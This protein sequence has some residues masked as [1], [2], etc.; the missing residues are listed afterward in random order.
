MA[1]S[2]QTLPFINQMLQPASGAAAGQGIADF[3]GG[4][5]GA[6]EARSRIDAADPD[7][8][9]HKFQNFVKAFNRTPGVIAE[10]ATPFGGSKGRLLA[11]EA[12]GLER[13]NSLNDQLDK[14]VKDPAGLAKEVGDLPIDQIPD[15]LT[16][17]AGLLANP[18]G[19][20][21]WQG[22]AEGYKQ[23]KLGQI[24]AGRIKYLSQLA[25][26]NIDLDVTTPEGLEEARRRNLE[27]PEQIGGAPLS[28][29]TPD[30][31]TGLLRPGY[32]ARDEALEELRR[33]Q[34]ERAT[35]QAEGRITTGTTPQIVKLHQEMQ[36]ALDE[37]DFDF[38][39]AL[40][41]NIDKTSIQQT[42][43]KLRLDQS[44]QRMVQQKDWTNLRLRLAQENLSAR[45]IDQALRQ[46]QAGAELVPSTQG[47]QPEGTPAAAPVFRSV[48]RPPTTAET[49]KAQ[50]QVQAN[51]ATLNQLDSTLQD[52]TLH[53]EAAGVRGKLF[54]L[55]EKVKGTLNPDLPAESATITGIQRSL[56]QAE[57]EIFNATRGG[58]RTS[59]W[60]LHKLANAGSLTGM[61][62]APNVA[63]VTLSRFKDLIAG[64]TIRRMNELKQ[65]ISDDVL[66]RV[67]SPAELADMNRNGIP[68]SKALVQRYLQLHPEFDPATGVRR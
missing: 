28:T 63:K 39:K 20:K 41:D 4:F 50:D 64:N 27:I 52:L 55:T 31:V 2:T 66:M 36:K 29:V 42:Q 8:K 48:A 3:I 13:T 61:L 11:A 60:E 26:Q 34:A 12:K 68:I 5:M 54:S 56:G 35:A 17:N 14:L 15:W 59:Q 57:Q 30:P 16:H 23:T 47:P 19:A 38:A 67:S 33:A 7:A 46:F 25:A 9:E 21:M 62:D 43:A 53:P 51:L 22:V 32:K 1:I 45:Q 24:E 58:I 40:Q 37:G 18:I 65:P 10:S 44:A 6:H 49:T